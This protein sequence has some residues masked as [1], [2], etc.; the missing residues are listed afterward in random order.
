MARS[1]T[2]VIP[3]RSEKF[4]VIPDQIKNMINECNDDTYVVSIEFT[5]TAGNRWER[6]PRGALK[7]PQAG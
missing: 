7:E 1:L 6:D 3:P 4:V 2:P 5:D